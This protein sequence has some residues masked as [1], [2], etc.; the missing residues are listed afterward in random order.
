ME[1]FQDQ[2]GIYANTRINVGELNQP[3]NGSNF[4]QDAELSNQLGRL[5][6]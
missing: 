3:L 2:G 6:Y 4:I 1:R 5:F